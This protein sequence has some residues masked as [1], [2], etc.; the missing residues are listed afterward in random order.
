MF[1]DSRSFPLVLFT[2]SKVS[3][4][5]TFTPGSSSWK[6]HCYT[7]CWFMFLLNHFPK[8]SRGSALKQSLGRQ[9]RVS[10]DQIL[11]LLSLHSRYTLLFSQ[12]WRIDSA[13]AQETLVFHDGGV[14]DFLT[15][16]WGNNH[17]FHGFDIL[18][19]LFSFSLS[20]E[21][22]ESI[23]CVCAVSSQLSHC[24]HSPHTLLHL[25]HKHNRKCVSLS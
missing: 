18:S 2:G 21:Q 11:R 16:F 10:G 23:V 6:D 13:S 5:H 9:C 22:N 8:Q 24:S 25:T 3:L 15:P 20:V 14:L 1:V 4:Y 17:F 19:L 7:C 12:L